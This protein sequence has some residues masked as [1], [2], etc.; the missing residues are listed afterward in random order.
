MGRVIETR[1]KMHMRHI[2]LGQPEKQAVAEHKF[3]T[4]QSIEFSNT[5]ILDK[6]PGYM[7]HVIK[8]AIKIMLHP[9]N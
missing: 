8:E 4:C 2:W 6:A 9:R 5:A 3:E 1:C 7:D